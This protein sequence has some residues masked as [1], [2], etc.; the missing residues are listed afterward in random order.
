MAVGMW[1]DFYNLFQKSMCVDSVL[2]VG[3]YI[4]FQ[5]TEKRMEKKSAVLRL[6]PT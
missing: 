1:L 2:A 3:G 5:K 4:V 6:G